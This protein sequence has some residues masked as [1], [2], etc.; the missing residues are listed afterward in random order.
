[1]K[2]WAAHLDALFERQRQR[3]V[4]RFVERQDLVPE[5]PPP[6]GRWR[7]PR[8]CPR[9]GRRSA[10]ARRQALPAPCRRRGRCCR[11][12]CRA[13]ARGRPPPRSWRR[14]ALSLTGTARMVAVPSSTRGRWPATADLVGCKPDRRRHRCIGEAG[15]PAGCKP[16]RRQLRAGRTADPRHRQRHRPGLG[17]QR[18]AWSRTGRRPCAEARPAA[19][20]CRSPDDRRR[21]ARCAG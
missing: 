2:L 20:R 18:A 15:V 5:T 21:R 1:M 12:P 14:I 11:S 7:G 19:P 13:A 4:A 8:R 10:P 3:P 17:R 6:Q 9:R 16:R